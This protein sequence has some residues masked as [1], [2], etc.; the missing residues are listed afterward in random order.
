MSGQNAKK[1]YR[2]VSMLVW[3]AA[4][5]ASTVGCDRLGGEP[6]TPGFMPSWVGARQSLESVLSAWRDAPDPLPNSFSTATV[7]F[8]DK[9]RKP[10]QRLS[11]FQI[12][13]QTDIENARQFTVRLTLDGEESPQ[14]VKYNIVGR[15]PVWIF[16]LEDY[17]M[18]SHWEHDMDEPAPGPTGKPKTE[19]HPAKAN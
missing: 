9:R 4:L 3:W 7:Q 14:L 5:G 2:R 15:N 12:L 6:A 19:E 11:A 17:E 16:R 1:G 13:S 8:V 18:F 10:N